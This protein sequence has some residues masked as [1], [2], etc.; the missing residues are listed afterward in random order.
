MDGIA[1]DAT[2]APT[3]W[4]CHGDNLVVLIHVYL[5]NRFNVVHSLHAPMHIREGQI[6]L[7][8]AFFLVTQAVEV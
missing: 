7:L 5:M 6:A 3:K 4:L 1:S 2:M 8:C